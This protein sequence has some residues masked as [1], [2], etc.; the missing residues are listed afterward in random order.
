[1]FVNGWQV[2]YL[3]LGAWNNLEEFLDERKWNIRALL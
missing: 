3:G 2:M 1:M